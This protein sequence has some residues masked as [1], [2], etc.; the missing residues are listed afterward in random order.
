MY[1]TLKNTLRAMEVSEGEELVKS[2]EVIVAVCTYLKG[3]LMITVFIYVPCYKTGINGE[4]YG[5]TY[6]NRGG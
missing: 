2:Q 1:Q 3:S 6:L 4:S 5:G